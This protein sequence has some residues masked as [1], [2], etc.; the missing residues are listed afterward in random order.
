[1]KQ[2]LVTGGAG[3]IG[4]HTCK[5][6]SQKGFQP[7]CFDNLSTGHEKSVKWGP[8]FKGDLRNK[9]DL[10][11]AFKRFSPAAVMHFAAACY[12]DESARD[13]FKYYDINVVGTLNLLT[14]M[15]EAGVKN[16]I[17]S[18]TC[19][20]YGIPSSIPIAETTPQLPINVYGKT[21][22]I[23]EE[24]I[25]EAI[26]TQ[27]L[28]AIML[29]Y[30]NAA[31]ADVEGEIGETHS[32]ETHLI[33]VV[34]RAMLKNEPISVFGE[35]Y[36]TIDGTAVRDYIHVLDL[37]EAHVKALNYVLDTSQSAAFNL[38][39]G[40]GYSIRQVLS[41]AQRVMEK[42]AQ[43]AY[44]PRRIGDPPALIADAT[45]AKMT[46]KW[47]PQYSD[48]PTILSSALHWQK[49]IINT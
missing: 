46:L 1:M 2:I 39:T 49:L 37:A 4:S 48:L 16:L 47:T 17:F 13:P 5:V 18:S 6:L 42:T 26:R 34:L 22:L 9:S 7:I 45:L 10:K 32:P 43:I 23:C 27:G 31:G 12:V 8:L 15:Q 33:P 36:P 40:N 21:K 25:R 11:T 14:A 35:D 24:M 41:V 44:K 28:S 38:G 3:F 29:R 20:T 19:S 30:F